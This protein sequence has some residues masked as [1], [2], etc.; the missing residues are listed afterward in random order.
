MP[1]VW[2]EGDCIKCAMC[3]EEAPKVF[4]FVE[5]VGPQVKTEIDIAAH[6]EDIKRAAQFCPTGCI[7]YS[8]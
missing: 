7:K 8:L 5:N 6:G 2:F 3:A 1:L 4:V